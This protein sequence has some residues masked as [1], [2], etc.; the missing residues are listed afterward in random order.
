MPLCYVAAAAVLIMTHIGGIN[1]GWFS[2]VIG[3][4]H[5]R[6][7]TVQLNLFVVK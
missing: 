4:A 5:V 1:T 7:S 6:Y 2:Y 3:D